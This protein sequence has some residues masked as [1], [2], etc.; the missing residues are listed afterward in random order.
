MLLGKNVRTDRGL[1]RFSEPAL[2]PIRRSEIVPQSTASYYL[3][4]CLQGL[5]WHCTPPCSRAPLVAAARLRYHGETQTPLPALVLV[6]Q[7]LAY[8]PGRTVAGSGP[9]LD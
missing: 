2:G 8:R 1:I 4:L 7:V 9:R 3:H 5:P 6:R